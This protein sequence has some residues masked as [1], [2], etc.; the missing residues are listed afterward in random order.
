MLTSANLSSTDFE[1]TASQLTYT[2]SGVSGGRH[3]LRRVD[4][5]EP[6]LPSEP[7]PEWLHVTAGGN[8]VADDVV[9][10]RSDLPVVVVAVHPPGY[11]GEERPCGA[12]L[13]EEV[14]A[15]QLADA[16]ATGQRREKARL[17]ACPEPFET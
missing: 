15:R 17:T 12:V 3:R 10:A 7:P 9:A 16:A 11:P 2:V 13:G 5:E 6:R 4:H 14:P 8:L 1:Q